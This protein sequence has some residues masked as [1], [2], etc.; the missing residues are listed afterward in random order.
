MIAE[1]ASHS[2]IHK[3]GRLPNPFPLNPDD[4]EDTDD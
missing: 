4:L 2:H 1:A 3:A